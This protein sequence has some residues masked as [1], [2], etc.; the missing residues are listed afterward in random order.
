MLQ[1]EIFNKHNLFKDP[2]VTPLV[3]QDS[4]F[5]KDSYSLKIGYFIQDENNFS[6][7]EDPILK[8]V[9]QLQKSGMKVVE[10]RPS[11]MKIAFELYLSLISGDGGSSLKRARYI[12]LEFNI[13][14]P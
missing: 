7:Y 4:L 13:R 3:F 5:E 9:D 8:V 10:F 2:D 1:K 6:I 12:I 14:G 11:F